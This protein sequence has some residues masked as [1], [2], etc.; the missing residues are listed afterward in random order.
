MTINDSGDCVHWHNME[1]H[2]AFANKQHKG[3][4]VDI[5]FLLS[6]QIM[7]FCICLLMFFAVN[8]FMFTS[9]PS[10]L[11]CLV[12]CFYDSIQHSLDN[13]TVY[14][15]TLWACR[16]GYTSHMLICPYAVIP[17]KGWISILWDCEMINSQF[18]PIRMP[19]PKHMGQ[20][21]SIKHCSCCNMWL[22]LQM[23]LR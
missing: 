12:S 11:G 8:I 21:I 1:H 13:P 6:F 15:S 9:P 19:D 4:N 22:M 23:I 20:N 17:V 2:R 5:L 3:Y 10:A 18:K 7:H 14:V 16:T